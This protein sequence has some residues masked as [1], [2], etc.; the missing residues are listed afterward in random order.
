[1]FGLY[2]GSFHPL[3]R[4]SYS[5]YEDG[6]DGLADALAYWTIK[7]DDQTA[8][9]D[10]DQHAEALLSTHEYSPW[11]LLEIMSEEHAKQ[12]MSG[13][14][15]KDIESIM[16]CPNLQKLVA[17]VACLD[18]QVSAP[19]E[20]ACDRFSLCEW[21]TQSDGN[22]RRLESSRTPPPGPRAATLTP[23]PMRMGGSGVFAW[24]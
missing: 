7:Y 8:V 12:D 20:R 21:V 19:L 6:E 2:R 11:R 17:K 1:M 22:R 9:A 10:W 24:Q 4:L 5:L 13:C 23:K 15:F 14:V 18:D 3:I 16:A